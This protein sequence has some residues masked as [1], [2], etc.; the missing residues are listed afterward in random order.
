MTWNF[1]NLAKQR[2]LT[3]LA[4]STVE[5]LE[6]RGSLLRRDNPRR[7]TFSSGTSFASA[8]DEKHPIDPQS[9]SASPGY[10]IRRNREKK[11]W[12]QINEFSYNTTVK[13]AADIT[14]YT[15]AVEFFNGN[16]CKIYFQDS[17][18]TCSLGSN[19]QYARLAERALLEVR[20]KYPIASITEHSVR[21]RCARVRNIF[22]P[23]YL[24]KRVQQLRKAYLLDD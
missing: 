3:N 8:V 13:M 17:G 7:Y 22:F 1:K 5:K 18:R 2:K 10:K 4:E 9:I 20:Y 23:V 12:K 24:F 6:T 19:F 14:N 16:F 15:L 21:N 11:F